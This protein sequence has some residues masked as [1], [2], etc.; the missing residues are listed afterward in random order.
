MSMG[1]G[2]CRGVLCTVI[3]LPNSLGVGGYLCVT[4]FQ[5]RGQSRPPTKSPEKTPVSGLKFRIESY[6]GHA[7]GAQALGFR[8]GLRA[9]GAGRRFQ[10]Q[11]QRRRQSHTH[12]GTPAGPGAGGG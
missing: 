2:V 9:H 4:Y 1:E 12:Q 10:G 8:I 3:G 7:Y 11:V 6:Y 5:W